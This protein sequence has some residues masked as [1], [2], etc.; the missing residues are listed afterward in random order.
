MV[1]PDGPE[2]E[3]AHLERG[4]QEFLVIGGIQAGARMHRGILVGRGLA[5]VT[6][7]GSPSPETHSV[8]LGREGDWR[9]RIG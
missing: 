1:L 3:V 7:E 9:Q 2:F 6:S 8:V 4:R 5:Q